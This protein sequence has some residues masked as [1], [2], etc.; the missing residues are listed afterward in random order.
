M[1]LAAG[2]R[3]YLAVVTFEKLN[4]EFRGG[5]ELYETIV[6]EEEGN[7]A[8]YLDKCLELFIEEQGVSAL[9]DLFKVVVEN[10]GKINYKEGQKQ[11]KKELQSGLQNLLGV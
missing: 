2:L 7:T 3:S 10:N 1:F 4:L 6:N 11:A 9:F 5:N 8:F